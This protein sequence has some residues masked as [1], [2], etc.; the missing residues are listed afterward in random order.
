MKG[1]FLI[2]TS[3]LAGFML[4]AT[5]PQP[6]MAESSTHDVV[7]SAHDSVVQTKS[8]ACVRTRWQGKSDPCA[9]SPPPP[10]PPAPVVQMPPPVVV[11]APPPA[12]PRTVIKQEDRTVYF[13]FNRDTLT[14]E[15]K[16]RLDA[17]AGVLRGAKDIQRAEIVGF[18]DP[19]GKTKYNQALSERRAH[20]VEAYLNERGYLNT[21]VAKV[22]AVGEDMASADCGGKKK[23]AKRIEC[24]ASDRKVEVQIVYS[25]QAR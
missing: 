9:P 19:M 6:A 25:T 4:C 18:A 11:Q 16:A 23:R 8:G 1:I 20:A 7:R 22:R 17:L 3:T 12:P 15:A 13:E 14:P 2:A 5:A 10:P 24:L 21:S